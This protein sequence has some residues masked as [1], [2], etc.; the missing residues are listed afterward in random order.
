MEKILVVKSLC[1]LLRSVT[2]FR[3][4]SSLE[5]MS[6]VIGMRASRMCLVMAD[7]ILEVVRSS[8]FSVIR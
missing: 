8:T 7:V 2:A 3:W 4:S 1:E 5:W 6:V